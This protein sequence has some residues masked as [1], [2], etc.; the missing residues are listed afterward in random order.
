MVC[1]PKFIAN[2]H[3]M[4]D[5]LHM[6]MNTGCKNVELQGEVLGLGNAWFDSKF[7]TNIFGFSHLIDLG[8]N[9]SYDSTVEVAFVC[10]HPNFDAVK[11]VRTRDRVYVYKPM[12]NYI[13]DMRDAEAMSRSEKNFEGFME[14]AGAICK[15]WKKS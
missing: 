8:Y 15:F 14:D 5:T 12:K 13:Q 2:V 3:P 1:N 11:F 7:I 10:K 9:I 4:T 6:T